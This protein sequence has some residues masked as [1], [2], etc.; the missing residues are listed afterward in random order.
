M[1]RPKPSQRSNFGKAGLPV[2]AEGADAVLAHRVE[3]GFGADR[4]RRL[5]RENFGYL[6]SGD[7]QNRPVGD[8]SK[9]AS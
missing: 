2:A 8:T 7:T 6:A 4:R 3:A 1:G 5:C 9:P